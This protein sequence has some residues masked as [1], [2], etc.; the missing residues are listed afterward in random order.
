MCF[1]LF[2]LHLSFLAGIAGV[3][4]VVV[5]VVVAVPVLVKD[6]AVVVAP[7]GVAVIQLE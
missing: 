4:G 2:L 3:K 5:V 1:C 7:G 6:L